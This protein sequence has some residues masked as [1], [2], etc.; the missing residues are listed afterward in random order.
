[1]GQLDGKVTIITGGTSGIGAHTAELF[2]AEGARV[3][4]AG[5]RIDGG[6]ARAAQIGATF[7][8]ADVSVEADV[9]A[10]I[11]GAV[12]RHGRLDVLVNN[13]G[14]FGTGGGVAEVDLKH[15]ERTMAVHV[16][17]VVAGM[18]HAA[19]VMLRQDRA[20][21]STSPASAGSLPA[22]PGWTTQPP[23]RPSSS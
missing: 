14:D 16:G 4:I 3:V 12:D 15:F 11:A 22:G 7:L 8:R 23:R 6:E 19:P 17:G 10:L 21:S 2:A 18:K 13:A 9:Q 20:A 5:R 1:M